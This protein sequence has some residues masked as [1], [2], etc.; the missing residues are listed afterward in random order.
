[1]AAPIST[2]A[3]TESK[4]LEGLSIWLMITKIFVGIMSIIG[5]IAL[6]IMIGLIFGELICALYGAF[7]ITVFV[8]K[9][10]YS[11]TLSLDISLLLFVIVI[12]FS[13]R[14]GDFPKPLGILLAAV[15]PPCF[16]YIWLICIF[17]SS[18]LPSSITPASL[19]SQGQ[20][21]T[22]YDKL[23]TSSWLYVILTVHWIY[24][25]YDNS[26]TICWCS[27]FYAVN[28]RSF[29]VIIWGSLIIHRWITFDLDY[30]FDSFWTRT[31]L[32]LSS[33]ETFA[34]MVMIPV[35]DQDISIL[36]VMVLF[37]VWWLLHVLVSCVS[38]VV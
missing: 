34:I 38:S 12:G 10:N 19:A 21:K 36:L 29:P 37:S 14:Y 22:S 11:S 13:L 9:R 3:S 18:S 7:I 4:E 31:L 16:G 30:E 27:S 15:S 35:P 33:L 26:N 2:Y 23:M 1:M 32:F 17:D 28:Q 5:F 24:Q 25:W 20:R 8:I 6:Q